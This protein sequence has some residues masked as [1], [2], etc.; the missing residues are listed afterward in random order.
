M[1]VAI[2]EQTKRGVITL[3]LSGTLLNDELV[4]LEAAWFW[5][6]TDPPDT[7]T[8]FLAIIAPSAIGEGAAFASLA[9]AKRLAAMPNAVMLEKSF[10]FSFVVVTIVPFLLRFR[11]FIY[12]KKWGSMDFQYNY[13]NAVY[14]LDIWG[15]RYHF[16]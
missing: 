1:I 13:L 12:D 7:A 4:K 15:N 10:N 5:A 2:A 9:P 14:G 16:Y 6:E 8:P 11:K 3:L